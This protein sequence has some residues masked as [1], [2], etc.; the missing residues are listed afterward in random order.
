M[1]EYFFILDLMYAIT[2]QNMS[3]LFDHKLIFF[4][5]FLN[6]ASTI[7]YNNALYIKTYFIVDL[8]KMILWLTLVKIRELNLRKLKM[9]YFFYRGGNR[10]YIHILLI[11]I[12]VNKTE[13]LRNN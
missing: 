6:L 7:P 1:F 2:F 11:K 10:Y 12:V 13:K 3:F 8:I 9:I 5:N 4:L